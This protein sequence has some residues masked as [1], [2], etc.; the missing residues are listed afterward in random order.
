[1]Y[2]HEIVPRTI[3]FL[4]A[5]PRGILDE[6]VRRLKMRGANKRK[7]EAYQIYD[8]CSSEEGNKA[9]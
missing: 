1:L 6:R 3:S 8:D 2:V 4:G 5:S 9:D 7:Q